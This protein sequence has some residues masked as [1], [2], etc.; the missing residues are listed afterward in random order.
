MSL[1]SH[2]PHSRV[3]S[4]LY[5]PCDILESLMSEVYLRRC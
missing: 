2:T 1:V 5:T 4:L 3:L